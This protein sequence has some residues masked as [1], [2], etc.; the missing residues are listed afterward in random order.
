M[1]S[2]CCLCIPIVNYVFLLFVHAFLLLSMYTYCWLCILIVRPC[3][4]VVVYVH[5]LLSTY[6]YCSSMYSYCCLCILIVVYVFLFFVH[7]FL[8]LSMYTYCCICILRRGYPDWGLS[9]LF[10]FFL[11][12]CQGITSQDGARPALFQNCCVVICIVCFVSFYVLSVCKRV[13]Y[14]CHRVTTKLQLTNISN[15]LKIK[16]KLV[17]DMLKYIF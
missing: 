6:S 12:K 7:V 17:D 14:Y 11:G 4:L 1:H 2:Y 13:L 8:L 16:M 15:L 9:V 10:F 5:L 3:I